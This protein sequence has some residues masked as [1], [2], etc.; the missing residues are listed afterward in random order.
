MNPASESRPL[1]PFLA[2]AASLVLVCGGLLI[3][4]STMPWNAPPESGSDT[5]AATVA[6]APA[7]APVSATIAFAPQSNDGMPPASD[8]TAAGDETVET[9]AVQPPEPQP[10]ERAPAETVQSDP[11]P[12]P[13][14]GA[15]AASSVQDGEEPPADMAETAAI[16]AMQTN[17]ED[18]AQVDETEAGATEAIA[19]ESMSVSEAE[20]M[21]QHMVE[22]GAVLETADVQAELAAAKTPQ[23]AMDQTGTLLAETKPAAIAT[24]TIAEH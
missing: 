9:A 15:L 3:L 20:P 22:P 14:D 19:A 5:P 11:S 8:E 21:P 23:A 18:V 4:T 1:P 7:E 24:E 12:V 17:A 13:E 10:A 2:I 6:D 16:D